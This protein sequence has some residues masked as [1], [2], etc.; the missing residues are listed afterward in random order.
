MHSDE[1]RQFPNSSQVG[2]TRAIPTRNIGFNGIQVSHPKAK[3]WLHV[4][5]FTIP[6]VVAVIKDFSDDV[7]LGAS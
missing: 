7:I 5:S 6:H 4:G 2:R 3:I 1:E